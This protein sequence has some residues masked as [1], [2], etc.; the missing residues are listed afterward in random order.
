MTGSKVSKRIWATSVVGTAVL[1][2]AGL[3]TTVDAAP[4]LVS[5][6]ATSQSSSASTG[7]TFSGF[8]LSGGDAV[9]ALVTYERAGANSATPASLTATYG[10]VEMTAL[11]VNQG[12]QHASIFYLLGASGS[13]D[14]VVTAGTSGALAASVI[15]LDNVDAVA[16]TDTGAGTSG[17]TPIVLDYNTAVDGGFVLG[18]FVDNAFSFQAT[19]AGAPSVTGDNIDTTALSLEGDWA[20]A[21]TSSAAHLHAYGD[22][23]TA[24]NYSN[25]Y[26]P[27]HTNS[28]RH[29]AAT[30]AFVSVVPEPASMALLA[31]G[32]GLMVFRRRP[33]A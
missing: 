19:N 3:A 10:G 9:V 28:T 22:V 18:A 12:N 17:T 15:A 11:T 32:A 30:V 24:G 5:N 14:V 7:F 21:A 2:G 8:D 20:G 26:S 13:G 1:C 23:A 25:S 31:A 33:T 27:G 16:S 29:A 6:T 4:I